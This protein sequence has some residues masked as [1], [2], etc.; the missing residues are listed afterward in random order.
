MKKRNER[1]RN[2]TLT[3]AVLITV[4]CGLAPTSPRARVRSLLAEINIPNLSLLHPLPRQ[5]LSLGRNG[6]ESQYAHIFFAE[7]LRISRRMYRVESG[8]SDNANAREVLYLH[9]RSVV[10]YIQMSL[11]KCN[12][13]CSYHMFRFCF[14]QCDVDISPL[15]RFPTFESEKIFV[16]AVGCSGRDRV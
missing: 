10:A 11:G 1:D 16:T 4:V 5:V 12:L 14:L 7:L 13:P 2:G 9:H 15:R 6:R 3:Q 8:M